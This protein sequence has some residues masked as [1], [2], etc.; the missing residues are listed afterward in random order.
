[1]A[2]VFLSYSIQDGRRACTFYTQVAVVSRLEA[3]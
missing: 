3:S 1:M 2:E